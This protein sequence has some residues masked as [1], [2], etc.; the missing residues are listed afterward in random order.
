ME[1]TM[2]FRKI[3]I[4]TALFL[5]FCY[6]Q[7]LNGQG[8]VKVDSNGKK[9][10]KSMNENHYA[11]FRWIA[12]SKVPLYEDN[13]EFSPTLTMLDAKDFVE[14]IGGKL[15]LALTKVRVYDKT[16]GYIEGW[17]KNKFFYEKDYYGEPLELSK[18]EL[19]RRKE[20]ILSKNRA[21]ENRKKRKL[22]NEKSEMLSSTIS[23]CR[24][25]LKNVI[26]MSFV[27]V[28]SYLKKQYKEDAAY[29]ENATKTVKFI[30]KKPKLRTALYFSMENSRINGV[31]IY[32]SMDGLSEK[33]ANI[34]LYEAVQEFFYSLEDVKNINDNITKSTGKMEKSG[35]PITVKTD[36][37]K[38]N[39]FIELSI[40]NFTGIE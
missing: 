31:L 40:G 29:N 35:M 33:Q 8:S 12:A 22:E 34:L 19:D 4:L 9:Y 18:Q 20:I 16:A 13:S 17:T 26:G 25:D 24:P 2:N 5:T 36:N 30:S 21:D 1:L 14:I 37:S 38:E 10:Y 3:L 23:A 27:Q 7:N 28:L 6:L 39:P 11:K 32:N 15:G